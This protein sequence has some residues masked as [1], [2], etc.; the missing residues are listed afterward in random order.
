MPKTTVAATAAHARKTADRD[1]DD[2][3]KLAHAARI[4]RAALAGGRL[5]LADLQ[6]ND[7]PSSDS[8]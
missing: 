1:I 5:T 2:P 7:A 6:P 4:I 3:A 8:A